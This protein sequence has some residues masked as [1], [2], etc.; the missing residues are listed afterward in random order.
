[1]RGTHTHLQLHMF[2]LQFLKFHYLTILNYVTVLGPIKNSSHNSPIT[3]PILQTQISV[4]KVTI[5]HKLTVFHLAKKFSLFYENYGCITV[6]KIS[7]DWILSSANA[8]QFA[9]LR[10]IFKISLGFISPYRYTFNTP[11]EIL[12]LPTN[13]M[14]MD[15]KL[16]TELT[17][18]YI[19]TESL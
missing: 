8:K 4:W 14:M 11:K 16:A 18:Y 12:V 17:L 2:P 1:M 5:L 15:H 7:R 13:H 6:F 3:Y 10:D 9:S 19:I